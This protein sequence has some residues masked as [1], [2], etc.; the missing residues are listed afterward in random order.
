MISLA[1]KET[2]ILVITN[3]NIDGTK[4]KIGAKKVFKDD[5]GGTWSSA[6]YISWLSI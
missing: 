3:E 5:V 4:T 6:A 1:K 2:P